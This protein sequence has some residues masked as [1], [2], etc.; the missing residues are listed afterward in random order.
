[1]IPSFAFAYT[2]N[3]YGVRG[4]T[5]SNG[6]YVS[7]YTRTRP[8]AYRYDNKSYTGGS[9]YNSSYYAPT[10]NYSSNWYTPVTPGYTNISPG[11]NQRWSTLHN[12][13]YG[14]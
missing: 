4:Y 1:M 5:K 2:S 3:Y 14:R 6:T 13:L 11:Y 10:R 8:N 9:L 12:Q 7:P